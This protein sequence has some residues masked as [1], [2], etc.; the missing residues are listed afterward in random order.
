MDLS[1]ILTIAVS[2]LLGVGG[3]IVNSRIQR[4]TN[5]IHTVTEKRVERRDKTQEC[6]ATLLLNSDLLVIKKGLNDDSLLEVSRC[7]TTLRSLHTFTYDKDKELIE[8]AEKLE[9]EIYA[10][11]SSNGNSDQSNLMDARNRFS[12]LADLYV[13][14]EWSRIKIETMGKRRFT[15]RNDKFGETYEEYSKKYI[16]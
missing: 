4:K 8:A 14:T 10:F 11:V 6:F 7:V 2:L 1:Q 16:D 9:K 5:S 12:K 15:G 13:Q 3:F